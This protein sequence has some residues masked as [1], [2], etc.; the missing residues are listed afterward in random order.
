MASRMRPAGPRPRAG[1]SRSSAQSMKRLCA[2]SRPVVRV[3]LV[4]K[5]DERRV[6]RTA[7]HEQ[8]HLLLRLVELL[9]EDAGELRALL[10][11]LEARLKVQLRAVELADELLEPLERLFVLHLFR[12][13]RLGHGLAPTLDRK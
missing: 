7:L 1:R 2:S 13:M 9:Q 8:L 12:F 4:I 5:W 6:A 3:R 10:E 11:L